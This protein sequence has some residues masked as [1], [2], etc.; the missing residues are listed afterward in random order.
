[1]MLIALIAVLVHALLIAGLAVV[2]LRLG[3]SRRWAAVAAFLVFGAAA[4]LAAA[5][6][7]PLET[8]ATV[9]PP[10]VLLGDWVYT[11]SIQAL[12]DPN[13]AQAH[14]TIPWILR[15]PQAYTLASLALYGAAGAVVQ[16]VWNRS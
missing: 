2:L 3:V 8:C 4:G 10:G 5:W 7:W 9:N 12:G 14:F 6:L 13:S 16:W 15:V 1:M 11:A